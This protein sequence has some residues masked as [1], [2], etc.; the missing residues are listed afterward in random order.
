MH[1]NQVVGEAGFAQCGDYNGFPK[2]A[3]ARPPSVSI[4]LFS[5]PPAPPSYMGRW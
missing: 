2:S 4:E 1:R 5:V 3:G